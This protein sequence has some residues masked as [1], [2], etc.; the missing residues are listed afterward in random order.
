MTGVEAL[1]RLRR[2]GVPAV[3]T[4]DAAAALASTPAAASAVLARLGKA[5]LVTPVR[6]GLWWLD[7]SVEPLRLPELLSW[8]QPS[9]VSLQSALWTHG[10][11]EQI[12]SV[13]YA[14]SL[15]RS[16]LVKT[17]LGVVSLHHVAPELFG[18]FDTTAR[19]VRIASPEKALFDLAYLSGGRS[20]RFAA[21]PELSLPRG[22]R[23]SALTGWVER[24]AATRKRTM[25]RA[26]LEGW[27][28]L[29]LD[30]ATGRRRP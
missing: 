23:R 27:L 18:G 3:R 26:R 1:A 28:R 10:L 20:R 8:P 16:Q 5:G 6:S 21:L 29:S 24:I 15:G 25:T 14:V 12:P 22:F 30:S 17:R 9:Y 7:P 19:G 4:A 2:L 13:T 11:I